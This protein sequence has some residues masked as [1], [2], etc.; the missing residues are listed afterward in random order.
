MRVI[1]V[2]SL[3]IFCTHISFSQA[4]LGLKFSPSFSTS[5][6]NLISDTLDIE[7]DGSKLKFSLGL[8]FDY[9]FSDTYTLSTGII[10]VPKTV[11]ISIAGENGGTY[12]NTFEAYNLQYLHVPLSLK[13]YTNEIIPDLAIFFQV[14]G[15]PEF[16]I[17][18]EPVEEE[19]SLIESFS[20]MD[21]SVLLGGGVEYRAGVNTVLFIDASYQRGLLNVVS[22]T[23]P[24]IGNEF[25]IRNTMLMLDFGIKF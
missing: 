4:K 14:G 21:I 16:K 17:F 1:I 12:P 25:A 24:D 10:F 3:L 13:L 6:T 11:Q 18:E 5:R 15:A 19:Y 8:I 2:F 20:F 23:T 9:P 7:N 22:E